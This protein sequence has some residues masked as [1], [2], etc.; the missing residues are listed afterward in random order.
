MTVAFVSIF[1]CNGLTN[2]LHDLDVF[3][4]T[5]SAINVTIPGVVAESAYRAG[6]AG[7]CWS[8][9]VTPTVNVNA[10]SIDITCV[11]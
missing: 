6:L 10:D 9:H 8:S 11:V 7:T 4:N 3:V 1:Y 2:F 5:L